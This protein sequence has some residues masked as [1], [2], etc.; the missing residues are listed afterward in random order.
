MT[1]GERL[2]P[3]LTG[4][5]PLRE[6]CFGRGVLNAIEDPWLC[7]ADIRESPVEHVKREFIG[8]YPNSKI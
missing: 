4:L 5:L 2:F 8:S 1:A 7:V 3:T 6:I